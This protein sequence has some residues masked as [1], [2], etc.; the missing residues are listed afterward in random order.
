MN[1]IIRKRDGNLEY[2]VDGVAVCIFPGEEV[3]E[4]TRLEGDRVIH[5][6]FFPGD[7]TPALVFELGPARQVKPEWIEAQIDHITR[8][9]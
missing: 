9:A 2:V 7:T 3:R 8:A 1:P 5:E 6:T 4:V